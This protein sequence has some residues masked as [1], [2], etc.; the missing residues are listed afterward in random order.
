MLM[1]D[2]PVSVKHTTKLLTIDDKQFERDC[3]EL[4][5]KYGLQLMNVLSSIIP[6]GH[7]YTPWFV[8]SPVKEGKVCQQNT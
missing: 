4:A 5:D 1:I 8:L 7:S 2:C 6:I 3:Q